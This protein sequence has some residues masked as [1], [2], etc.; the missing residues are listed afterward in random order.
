M[1]QS[2]L[3]EPVASVRPAPRPRLRQLSLLALAGVAVAATLAYAGRRIHLLSRDV[4]SLEREAQELRAQREH[5]LT[6]QR[7]EASWRT[8]ALE[9]TGRKQDLERTLGTLREEVRSNR[10]LSAS[11]EQELRQVIG[12]LR[13]EI[14]AAEVTIQ[15]LSGGQPVQGR[16][17]SEK[18]EPVK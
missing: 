1:S 13:E 11:R 10:A 5:W 6:A 2:L 3:E 9:E 4:E 15:R 18:S 14:T 12:F 8:R 17:I 16:D 7:R